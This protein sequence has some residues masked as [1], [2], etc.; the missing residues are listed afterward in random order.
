MLSTIGNPAAESDA[1]FWA[2][3]MQEHAMFLFLLIENNDLA[4]R[5]KSIDLTWGNVRPLLSGKTRQ[6]QTRLL[7]FP[8][9]ELRVLLAEIVERQAKGEWLG[10][11]WPRFIDHL[12][13]ELDY[14]WSV[15]SGRPQNPEEVLCTWLGF[16]ADHASFAAHLLD[17]SE[18]RK[19]QQALSAQQ[20]LAQLGCACSRPPLPPPA[21]PVSGCQA[22]TLGTLLTLSKKAGADLD[23]YFANLGVG[24]PQLKSIIHPVLAIHVVREGRRFLATLDAL[25]SAV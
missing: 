12:L 4:R 7:A 1:E 25:K 22:A 21:A 14:A 11:A 24:T 23:N 17:P 2:R 19:I 5:A 13:E 18:S 15:V 10:W 20:V 9:H 3:Q 16:M 8:M 6:E